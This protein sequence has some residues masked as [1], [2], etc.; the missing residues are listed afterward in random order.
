MNK[1]KKRACVLL[2][3]GLLLICAALGVHVTQLRQDKMAGQTASVLLQQLELNQIPITDAQEQ[4]DSAVSDPLLPQR[5]YMGY[6]MIGSLSIPSVNIHLPILDDWDD[7]MLKVAPCRYQGSISEGNLII[8]GHNYKSHFTPLRQVR[9][10]AEVEF[11]NV[12]GKVFRYKVAA[13]EILHRNDGAQ[14]A[15]SYP[16][17]IFTCTPGGIKRFVV[18]CVSVEE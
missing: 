4:P 12:D 7:A 9:P 13:I 15:S 16:L 11:T 6:H 17:T 18:R 5:Q 14:L 1:H 10:G 3:I 2:L 8:M